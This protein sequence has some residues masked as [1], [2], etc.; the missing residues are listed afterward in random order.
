MNTQCTD[1]ASNLLCL[2]S[3]LSP[4]SIAVVGAS[5]SVSR[6][7]GIPLDYLRRFGYAGDIYP[8]NPNTPKVQGMRAYESLADIARRVDLAIVAVPQS[9]LLGVMEDAAAAHVRSMVLFSSGYAEVGEAG[10][11][12]QETLAAKA[13]EAGIRLIGPN[14]LG[15]MN[16]ARHVYATFSPAPGMGRVKS[17]H[18]GL[19]SQSGA[20]GAYAYALARDR[21]VGFSKWI[22]TGNEADIQVAD[23][24]SLLAG[25]F[26]TDVIMVY[27]EGCRDGARLMAALQKAQ[28]CGKPVV[29][30]KVGSTRAGAQVAASH[31]A[32]LVGNDEVYNAVFRKYGVLRAYSLT[33][34]FDLAHSV[35]IAGRPRNA[36]VGVLTVSGG[37]GALMADDCER[38]GL[39]LPT[40]SEGAQQTLR[41]WVP[42]A[43]PRNPVD[44]TGQVTNDVSL[45]ERS[46][47]LML[48]DQDFGSWVCFMATVGASQKIWPALLQLIASLRIA[49]PDKLLALCTLLPADK[50]EQLES[51][52]CL[53]FDDPSDCIRVLAA[54]ASG[55]NE[56]RLEDS[57][58]RALAQDPGCASDDTTVSGSCLQLPAYRLNEAQAMEVLACAGVPMVQRRWVTSAQQAAE[59]ALEMGGEVAVKV[60]SADIA[61]KSDCGGVALRVM[62]A[63]AVSEAF[64]RVTANARKAH[65]HASL[66][67]ALITP[68]VTD[69]I[70]CIAGVHRD[71]VFGQV[72]MFGAGGVHSE[73]MNDVT[74]RLLP[75]SMQDALEM[76]GE[77]RISPLLQGMRGQAGADLQRL[78]KTL[79]SLAALAQ[80]L[81]PQLQSVEINPLLVRTGALGDC[82]AAD[83]LIVPCVD[84]EAS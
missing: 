82:V 76:L 54:L 40:L 78:A 73:A 77:L 34:F 69:G 43:A 57:A 39:S 46:A 62:G 30:I 25:D 31:T 16:V 51:L 41:E 7:G 1:P 84:R 22:T 50:R 68:M 6:V 53:V 37:V 61:H 24:I 5:D 60:V 14:C 20:F 67:G 71:P 33:E 26:D 58:S 47:R 3:L 64:E 65:P 75:V 23:C 48:E 28:H 63:K 36:S 10:Q 72:L 56:A 27:M 17:G 15:Y 8:V 44:I 80:R 21:G 18:I 45:L 55:V 11:R 70:E 2:E 35:A 59:A 49:Y 42:F 4:R 52:R 81:G 12:A 9:Q 74:F 66:K 19:V 79:C 29:M 83:A 32:A 38:Q 13:A